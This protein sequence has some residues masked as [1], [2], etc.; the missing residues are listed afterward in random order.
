VQDRRRSK[1]RT[2]TEAKAEHYIVLILI[3]KPKK[4]YLL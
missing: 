4:K 2:F 3:K 1:S